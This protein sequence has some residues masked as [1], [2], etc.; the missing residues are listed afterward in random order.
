MN[1]SVLILDWPP[2]SGN[3]MAALREGL[4]QSGYETLCFSRREGGWR[5]KIDE[6]LDSRLP[7]YFLC[8]RRLFNPIDQVVVDKIRR[9]GV[10]TLFFDFGV[11][12]GTLLFDPWG[13]GPASEI[14]LKGMDALLRNPAQ[15]RWAAERVCELVR[16]RESLLHEMGR[17]APLKGVPP[18]FTLLLLPCKTELRVWH[19]A[20]RREWCE[21]L[22]IARG[23]TA[24][25]EGRGAGH[26]LVKPHPRDCTWWW[27]GPAEGAR[28]RVLPRTRFGQ[29]GGGSLAWLLREADRVV[30][31]GSRAVLAPLALNKRVA[32]L[33]RGWWS[34]NEVLLELDRFDQVFAPWP[35]FDLARRGLFLSLIFSRQ[36][37]T[38]K[39]S[40]ATGV[41]K[42]LSSFEAVADWP[43]LRPLS[44]ARKR[45]PENL[46]RHLDSPI[47]TTIG[48]PLDP[49]QWRYPN[50]ERRI[51]ENVL[52]T[53]W[54]RQI[55]VDQ[56]STT[57]RQWLESQGH[58]FCVEGASF[59]GEPP[60]MA[61]MLGVAIRQMHG[62]TIWTVEQDARLTAE[63]KRAAELLFAE[64]ADDVAALELRAVDEGGETCHPSIASW[65]RE[66]KVVGG[67]LNLKFA[68]WS[69]TLWR[70]EGLMQVD[71]DSLPP[72]HR[73]DIEAGKQLAQRGWRF[74]GAWNLTYVH[75]PH[76]SNPKDTDDQRETNRMD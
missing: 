36:W 4:G 23:L 60:R 69:A 47:V 39:M 30:A 8:F 10:R 73:S 64:L 38:S 43:P 41:E 76:S 75:T 17:A 74:K 56:C 51:A 27:E 45:P 53:R 15:A 13:D 71:F 21:P 6:L 7:D 59:G 31:F 3:A 46:S 49:K 68:S 26:L 61:K 2:Y 52:A 16:W 37:P 42:V 1:R 18:N 24:Q 32:A 33:S 67:L 22:A 62:P 50:L 72:L 12:P 66:E 54:P 29:E 58:D 11:Q 48:C 35:D 5:E 9:L 44:V 34:G 57:L 63:V 65:W 14:A 40:E 20:R 19:D 55:C 25:F 28:W 70:R